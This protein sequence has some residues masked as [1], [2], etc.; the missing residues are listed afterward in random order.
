MN[1]PTDCVGNQLYKDD[2]VIVHF[3]QPAVFKIIAVQEGSNQKPTLL[4]LICD[5]TI[6][7]PSGSQ[8]MSLAKVT[9]PSTIKLVE[10]I[11]EGI[12]P[13]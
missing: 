5:M 6:G 2:L 13:T 9:S 1:H 3:Q 7:S 10:R 11:V 8:I 12:T 4:R